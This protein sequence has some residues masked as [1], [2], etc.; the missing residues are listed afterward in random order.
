MTVIDLSKERV[1]TLADARKY[2]PHRRR[3]AKPALATLYGWTTHGCRGVVLESLR[4]GA[5]L[6]T[7]RE[8][9]QRWCEKLTSANGVTTPSPTRQRKKEIAA[10]KKACEQ[11]GL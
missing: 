10:A 4:V 1:V 11:E 8:A 3:G 7:S 9:I 6:C 2:F 5:T